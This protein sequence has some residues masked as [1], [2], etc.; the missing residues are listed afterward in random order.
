MTFITGISSK[1]TYSDRKRSNIRYLTYE[2]RCNNAEFCGLKINRTEGDI[3][4]LSGKT[5]SLEN[6]DISK[7]VLKLEQKILNAVSNEDLILIAQEMNKCTEAEK[8]VLMPKFIEKQNDIDKNLYQ[9]K[10]I[11]PQNIFSEIF[12]TN[13]S[14]EEADKL[15]SKYK[16]IIDE[17]DLKIFINK[18]FSEVKHDFGLEYLPIEVQIKELPGDTIGGTNGFMSNFMDF[19]KITYYKDNQLARKSI[20][21]VVMHELNHAKQQEIAIATDSQA[22]IKA[23]AANSKK[24]NKQKFPVDLLEKYYLMQIGNKKINDIKNKIGKIK[25]GSTLYKQG[26]AYINSIQNYEEM[27]KFDANT[28]QRYKEQL[29]EKES[30]EVQY[31]ADELYYYLTHLK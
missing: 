8:S 4:E 24:N 31:K 13:I 30:Y 6:T 2:N 25:E 27:T 1:E 18:L 3:I 11:S 5:K 23:I 20:F 15:C 9:N 7:K 12:R 28:Y 14:K 21:S 17:P 16:A 26:K 19:V 22:Y 10:D 29:V